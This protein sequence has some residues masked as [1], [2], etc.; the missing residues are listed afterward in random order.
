M[1]SYMGYIK[2]TDTYGSYI[3]H[4][5][6]YVNIGKL[7]KFVAKRAKAERRAGQCLLTEPQRERRQKSRQ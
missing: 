6:P 3:N 7:K 1:I 2:H 5:R 4:I